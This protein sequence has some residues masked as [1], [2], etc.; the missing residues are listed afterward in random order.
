MLFCAFAC[1]CFAQKVSYGIKAGAN[2]SSMYRNFGAPYTSDL[3]LGFNAGAI[4]NITFNRLVIRPGVFYSTKGE[5]ENAKLMDITGT[6]IGPTKT[7]LRLNY[8]EV[9]V[10]VLYKIPVGNNNAINLGGGGYFGYGLSGSISRDGQDPY[11]VKFGNSTGVFDLRL[12]NPDFGVN[13][14]AGAGIKDRYLIEAGYSYGFGNLSPSANSTLNNRTLSF[15][16]GY[17]F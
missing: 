6:V 4:V 10:N 8:L 16:V 3:L 2:L 12:N 9:P 17:I 13:V 14:I 7:K 11:P 1:V 15:S 5:T